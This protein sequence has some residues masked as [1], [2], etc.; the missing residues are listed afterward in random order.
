[1]AGRRNLSRQLR[2][3]RVSLSFRHPSFLFLQ[4]LQILCKSESESESESESK[5]EYH[6][7]RE[8]QGQVTY[9]THA[10][11]LCMAEAHTYIYTCMRK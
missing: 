6:S 5:S 10:G 1:M 7:Q 2:D 3:D 4:G 9:G 11:S 8:P